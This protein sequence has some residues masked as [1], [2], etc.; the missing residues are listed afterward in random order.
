MLPSNDGKA[1]ADTKK[2][3]YIRALEDAQKARYIENRT[4]L[5]TGIGEAADDLQRSYDRARS[6]INK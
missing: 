6:R 1:S 4:D 5:K 2:H 3:A